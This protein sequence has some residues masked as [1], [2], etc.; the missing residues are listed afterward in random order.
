MDRAQGIYSLVFIDYFELCA[1]VNMQKNIRKGIAQELEFDAATELADIQKRRT[2][3]RQLSQRRS[4][5]DRWRA[6]LVQLRRMGAS[7]GDLILW[8]R[9]RRIRAHA[10]TVSRYLAKLPE[11]NDG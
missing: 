11:L 1:I 3:G 9:S 8:L 7:L 4:R 2:I 10:S 6:E 5:L